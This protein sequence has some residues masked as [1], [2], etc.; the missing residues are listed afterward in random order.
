MGNHKFGRENVEV[1]HFFS[2]QSTKQG[3][4]QNLEGAQK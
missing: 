1:L 4:I 2:D 3:C